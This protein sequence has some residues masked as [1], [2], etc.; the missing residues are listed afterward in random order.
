MVGSPRYS[1]LCNREMMMMS[2]SADQ[3]S[4]R[5]EFRP[6]APSGPTV[7][8]GRRVGGRKGR[9]GLTRRLWLCGLVGLLGSLA[10]VHSRH[11][12]AGDRDS[13]L[14]SSTQQT[15]LGE[16]EIGVATAERKGS[17]FVYVNLHDD[18]NTGVEAGLEALNL[19]GG[20]LIELRHDGRRHLTFT[21]RGKDYRVDPNRIFTLA[22]VRATLEK[23]SRY[24]EDAADAVGQF[25]KEL[26]AVYRIDR[27]DAVIALHNNTEGAYSAL[28]YAAGGD[29]VHDAE[30]VHIRD[31][32][33]PDD[34]F[35]VTERPV[36]DALK[37]R[38]Y[39]VV[40]QDNRSVTDDGSLS[41]YCGK[42]NVRYVNVEAQDGHLKEQARMILDLKSVL[43]EL[44][45]VKPR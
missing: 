25:A 39:N 41:V 43:D 17:R 34:F 44:G 2:S 5:P 14:K 10:S 28:S 4:C 21:L 1:K 35:F 11:C 32:G 42:A 18:E 45:P 27:P 15:R 38:G 7:D 6:L 19:S 8:Q 9:F 33:D 24:A 23:Q 30:A 36:F 37:R 16:T 3:R 22:G 26:L 29:L 13:P 31:G 20:R 40:L 12:R